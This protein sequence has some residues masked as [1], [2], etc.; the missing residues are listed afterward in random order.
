MASTWIKLAAAVTALGLASGCAKTLSR[1]KKCAL[2]Q[3]CP[4]D[5]PECTEDRC[6]PLC[7]RSFEPLESLLPM[8]TPGPILKQCSSQPQLQPRRVPDRVHRSILTA[9]RRSGRG[10]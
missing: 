5:D 8:A 1:L 3:R 7:Q 9:L 4:S 2:E 10:H 6:T